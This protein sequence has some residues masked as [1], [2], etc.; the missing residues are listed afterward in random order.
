VKAKAECKSTYLDQ[1]S[2]KLWSNYVGYLDHFRWIFS[3][4]WNFGLG[5]K[6]R[7]SEITSLWSNS[8]LR[9]N[10]SSAKD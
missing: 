6:C 5:P 10:F 2:T 8:V 7:L 1:S 4:S 3:P 9:P